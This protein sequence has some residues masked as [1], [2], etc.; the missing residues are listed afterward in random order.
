MCI[1][2][3]WIFPFIFLSAVSDLDNHSKDPLQSW[4]YFSPLISLM[5]SEEA[6]KWSANFLDI[7][8]WAGLICPIWHTWGCFI[9]SLGLILLGISALLSSSGLRPFNHLFGGASFGFFIPKIPDLSGLQNSRRYCFALL[10]RAP[11]SMIPVFCYYHIKRKN[12]S[13]GWFH[14]LWQAF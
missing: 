12:V 8:E 6:P 14:S 2:T 5:F 4:G 3:P 11:G 7:H 1:S 10:S 9:L 13:S